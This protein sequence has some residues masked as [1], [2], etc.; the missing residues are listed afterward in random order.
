MSQGYPGCLTAKEMAETA[1]ATAM[2]SW[3][4]RHVLLSE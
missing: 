4:K 1:M 3:A 2:A